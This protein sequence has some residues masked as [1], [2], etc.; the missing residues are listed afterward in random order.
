MA[1]SSKTR[2][3]IGPDPPSVLLL[4]EG[5]STEITSAADIFETDAAQ[6]ERKRYVP[7]EC[8]NSFSSV[9]FAG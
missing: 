3:F 8:G 1:G 9:P 4:V 7:I 5:Y 6:K 2:I